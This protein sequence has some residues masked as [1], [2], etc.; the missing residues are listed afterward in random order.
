MSNFMQ[1]RKES[2]LIEKRAEQLFQELREMERDGRVTSK[3]AYLREFYSRLRRFYDTIDSPMFQVREADM[4]PVLEDYQRMTAELVQD[5]ETLVLEGSHIKERMDERF[6]ESEIDRLILS[7]RMRSAEDQIEALSK[8][9]EQ[10]VGYSLFRDSFINQSLQDIER[11]DTYPGQTWTREGV[12]TL[13]P[14]EMQ[15]HIERATVRIRSGNGLPGNTKQASGKEGEI[16]FAGEESLHLDLAS[17]LDGN[18]DT[19][20][21]YERFRISQDTLDETRG[22][23]FEYAEG[24]SWRK[25]DDSALALEIEIELERTLPVNWLSLNPFLPGEI[26]ARPAVIQQVEV[27]DGKGGKFQAVKAPTRFSEEHVYLFARTPCRKIV[28]TLAQDHAY[29]VEVG[30]HYKQV[31]DKGEMSYL[32]RMRHKPGRR[33]EGDNPS[34]TALGLSYDHEEKEIAYPDI[35]AASVLEKPEEAKAALFQERVAEPAEDPVVTGVELLPAEREVIGIRDIGVAS[36]T[37]EQTSEYVSVPL[38]VERDIVGASLTLNAEV[39]ESFGEGDWVRCYLSPDDGANWHRIAPQGSVGVEGKVM[40]LFNTRTPVEGRIPFFGYLDL[41]E[42]VKALRVKFE[43]ERPQ[44]MDQETPVLKE[45]ILQVATG[46][47]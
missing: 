20:F 6:Q 31:V 3:A 25:K 21:E 22:Y 42:P 43:L 12:L 36:Y 46:G 7:E 5:L 8:Q 4:L 33:I 9:L 15:S 45:Y 41:S 14:K 37:F 13:K 19:W 16:R 32:E 44:G 35:T 34:L 17:L 30:H 27:H 11:S 26:G 18:P 10:G 2:K 28:V 24:V 40:Y 47:V 38:E 29:P 1:I 23:G 39:P